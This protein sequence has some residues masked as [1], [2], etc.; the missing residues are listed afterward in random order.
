VCQSLTPAQHAQLWAIV[1]CDQ[2]Q[3]N[4]PICESLVALGLVRVEGDRYVTTHDGS[5]V[6]SL[7]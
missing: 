6:A 1:Q 5:Y 7:R 3:V 4:T 2:K